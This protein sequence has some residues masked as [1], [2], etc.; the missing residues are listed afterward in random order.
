MVA[1]PL[2]ATVVTAI[3]RCDFCAAKYGPFRR[4]TNVRFLMFIAVP[5]LGVVSFSVLVRPA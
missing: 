4:A 1:S 5:L 2:A 3:L